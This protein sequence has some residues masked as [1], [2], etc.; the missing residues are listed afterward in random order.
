MLS[1]S[2]VDFFFK[3]LKESYVVDYHRSQ[4]QMG[5]AF[6]WLPIR[7]CFLTKQIL[8]GL[9][10]LPAICYLSVSTVNQSTYEYCLVEYLWVYQSKNKGSNYI[11][12]QLQ[13]VRNDFLDTAWFS[14]FWGMPRLFRGNF[15]NTQ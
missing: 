8:L 14:I 6:F 13:R 5:E 12:T 10:K 1:I 3:T 2:W 11:F 9:C 7:K 15:Q 4:K